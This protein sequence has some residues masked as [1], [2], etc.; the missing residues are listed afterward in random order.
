MKT[1]SAKV[2]F[3]FI[4]SIISS[5]V[6][7]AKNNAYSFDFS[8][9]STDTSYNYFARPNSADL[10]N[11]IDLPKNKSTSATRYFIEKNNGS[12]SW[13]ALYAPLEI[14]Y[15]FNSNKDF[16]FNETGFSRNSKT[17]VV[18]KFNSY[19]FG[20]RRNRNMN[21]TRFYYGGI[22]KIREAS[23]CVVQSNASDC[24][25]NIGPVPLLNI[26]FEQ[27]GQLFY[28]KSNL[29]GLYSSR[30]SAYDINIE[31]GLSLSFFK[32]GMGVR[33]LGGGANSDKVKNFAQFRSIYLNLNL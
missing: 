25:E 28:I 8:Y 23:L 21:N 29:D 20:I 19:R 11:R 7:S 4:F 22:L 24:Y 10:N 12:W 15:Q 30:G 6:S 2:T 16:L 27:Q 13:T 5:K 31:T 14:N 32:I 26:G 33:M 9:L 17:T 1:L 3:F 18:Y